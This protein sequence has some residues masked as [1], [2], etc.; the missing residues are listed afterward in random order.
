V[1]AG[2]ACISEQSVGSAGASQ[3]TASWRW[4]ESH[5]VLIVF[6]DASMV[7]VQTWLIG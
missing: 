3:A 2:S 1:T 5:R 7:A 4:I 6:G